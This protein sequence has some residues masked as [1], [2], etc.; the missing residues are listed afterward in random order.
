MGR[1]PLL[2][3]WAILGTGLATAQSPPTQSALNA[4]SFTKN[5]SSS[6][7]I[8]PVEKEPE[9]VLD[10][11]SLLPD[12]PPA[13]AGST[14]VI[15]GTIERVDHVQDQVTVQA[16]GG[17]RMKVLFDPRT[18]IY[19]DGVKISPSELRPGDRVYVD[20]TLDGSAIF[21]RSIRLKGT[22]AVG[23]SQGVIVSFR[24]EKGELL[25]RDAIS[26]EP[27]KVRV[28]PSTRV[29]KGDRTMSSSALIPG[30]LVAL[31]F[32]AQQK[33][34]GVAREV[35]ILAERGASFVFAGQVTFLDLHAGL[36]VL[37]SSTDNKT[38]EVHFDPSVLRIDDNLRQ[39]ANVTVDAR[40]E[41]DRYYARNL[42]IN[43]E[44]NR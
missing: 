32:G 33:G 1:L 16:F 12:L 40:F 13:P 3:V 11:A 17:S 14:T 4:D 25:V 15:G 29:T 39:G 9:I 43:P 21:A 20:T 10:A 24:P 6:D 36:L 28:G 18:G 38:Y 19:R 27:I 44:T 7:S 2:A 8:Q 41:G 23:E 5:S 31:K 30:T 37:K 22:A 42:T 35:S 26:P 34:G